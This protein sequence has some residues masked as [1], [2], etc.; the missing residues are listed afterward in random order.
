ML[1]VD[2]SNERAQ[3]ADRMAQPLCGEVIH[4]WPT[5]QLD[6]NILQRNQSR[7]H[8]LTMTRVYRRADGKASIAQDIG[9]P[10]DQIIDPLPGLSRNAASC[11]ISLCLQDDIPLNGVDLRRVPFFQ[12][13]NTQVGVPR[14]L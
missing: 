4:I 1:S 9:N 14:A 7:A 5:L 11:Q 10:G 8:R 13:K 6:K 12:K 2:E 3:V